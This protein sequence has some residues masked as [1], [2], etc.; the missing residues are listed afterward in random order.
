LLRTVYSVL[1]RSPA[2]LLKEVILVDDFSDK[3]HLKKML[4]DDIKSLP[5]V[6]LLR[7]DKR[8]G[9]IRAR[10]KGAID[11]KGKVLIFLDSHCECAEGK[12]NQK[13]I[14]LIFDCCLRKGWLEPLLDPIAR[15]PKA[16]VVPLIEIIDD[17]T[18]Q[19]IG[20]PIQNIQVGGFDWNLIFNWHVT[21]EKEMKRRQK[22][23]DPIRSPT[24]AGGLFAIDRDWFD[25]LGMYDPGMD[26]WGGENLELSFK[27]WQCGGE[28]LCAPC[29]HV[30]HIFRKRSPYQWPSN[31]NVVKKNTVRL[32]EVWLDDYK[33]YYYE[34]ISNDLGDFGDVS[35]RLKIRERLQCKSFKWFLDN[36]YPEQFVPGESLYFVEIRSRAKA[37]Y[38]V[39]SQEVDDGD[40]PVIGYPCHGL[41][42]NQFFLMSKTF[43]IRREEKCLDYAGGQ[44]ELHKPGKIVSFNCHSMQGNQMWTY[45]ND[46][47]RHAS[48]FCVELSSENNKDIYM[49]MCEPT[50]EYQKWFWKKRLH[51]STNT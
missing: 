46:M 43:E 5:K 21:P 44:S 45:E 26:I 24:M 47:L 25:Q 41:A 1:D 7:A 17:S 49:A 40:K 2:H 9:L 4:E 10:L 37:N 19:V 31:V 3:E 22:K 6:R 48:G 12:E 8:E 16:A 29:S 39:D 38:C 14:D 30:G 50:N 32:A 27:L 33:K 11:A 18:F 34:R 42:G 36:V 35:D 51:N 20:T 23:T 28:L 15:N 13:K